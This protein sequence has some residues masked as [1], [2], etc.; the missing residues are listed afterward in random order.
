MKGLWFL[1][2]LAALVS[3]SP[4]GAEPQLQNPPPASYPYY[5]QPPVYRPAV[6]Y[7]PYHRPTLVGEWILGPIWVPFPQPPQCPARPQ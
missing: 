1:V 6:I 3:T 4:A 7:V 2:L 5:Y